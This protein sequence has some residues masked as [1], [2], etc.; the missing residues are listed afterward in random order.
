[1]PAE[2]SLRSRCVELSTRL[3][4]RLRRVEPDVTVKIARFGNQARKISD[5]DFLTAA[6]IDR[7][8]ALVAFGG[9]DDALSAIALRTETH[10]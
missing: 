1:M 4:V 3:T 6:K 2:S 5:A 9:R 8:R 10:G 7:L